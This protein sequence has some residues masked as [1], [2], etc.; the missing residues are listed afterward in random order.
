M[1][2]KR[3][4]EILDRPSLFGVDKLSD[5]QLLGFL[6]E[7][8]F[9]A[10]FNKEFFEDEVRRRGINEDDFIL[11]KQHYSSTEPKL[12]TESSMGLWGI[13]IVAAIFSLL[14]VM[15][16]LSISTIVIV[17]LSIFIILRSGITGRSINYYWRIFGW[18]MLVLLVILV[19]GISVYEK[20]VNG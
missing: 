8:H 16:L 1:S 9:F 20:L 14:T 10:T 11:L 7:E 3:S 2:A 19:A 17:V 4:D 15:P 5:N 13:V 18:V 6:E 12:K